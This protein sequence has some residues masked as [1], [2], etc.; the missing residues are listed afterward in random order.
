MDKWR[1]R[2]IDNKE[3]GKKN[4]KRLSN[5]SE[6]AT[7]MAK[8]LQLDSISDEIIELERTGRFGLLYMK[9]KVC[10]WE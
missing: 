1:R 3:K 10:G 6:R 4:Y 9:T 7:D 2:N 5:K 8:K